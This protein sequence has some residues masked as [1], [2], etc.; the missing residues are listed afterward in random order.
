MTIYRKNINFVPAELRPQIHLPNE[1]IPMT[2]VSMMLI[3]AI[4][5]SVYFYFEKSV[6]SKT[7]A[8]ID[9]ENAKIAE[10]IKYLSK[11]NRVIEQKGE[12]LSSLQK[13]LSRKNYWSE[14]F[15]ELSILT[16]KDIWLTS[17]NNS[18]PQIL[19]LSGESTRLD[20]VPRFLKALETSHH[21]YGVQI[22]YTQKDTNVVP[23]RYTFEFSI[24]VKAS[25][26][27]GS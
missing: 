2:L 8:T 16:P 15:K 21:F 27:G 25:I 12:T 9:A 6:V 20:A 13:V 24:P 4:A 14:I 11:E 23:T 7:L 1:V 26:G 22:N 10:S 18:D 3:Y 5:S 19:I 17:L